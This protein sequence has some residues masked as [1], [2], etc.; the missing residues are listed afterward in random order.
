[1]LRTF[2]ALPRLAPLLTLTALAG[3]QLESGGA[4]PSTYLALSGSVPTVS[5]PAVD[6]AAMLAEDAGAEGQGPLRFGAEIAVDLGFEAGEWVT[7]DGGDR[8]W[9]MRVLSSGAYSLS[10]VFSAWDLPPGAE[11]YL[12]NDDRSWTFGQF[13]A[14]NDKPD[15]RMAIRPLAGEAVTLEYLE[16][17]WVE[18]PGVLRIGTVVHDYRDVNAILFGE[19]ADGDCEIDVQ[20]PQGVGWEDQVRAV[21]RLQVGG[22]LCSGSLVNNTS[23]DGKQ[24]YISAQHCGSMSTGIFSFKYQHSGCGTGIAPTGFSLQGAQ[25]LAES[26]TLDLQLGR[27]LT[28]IPSTYEPYL[29]GWDRTG[30]TPASTVTIHHPNG[31]PKKISFDDDPPQKSGTQ[32]RIV[33]WDLGVTEDG[34]SGAPLYSPQGRFVGQLCCGQATCDSPFNDYFGRLDAQWSQLAAHLDPLGTGQTTLDGHDPYAAPL[35]VIAVL[36]G[37]VDAL[38][39]GTAQTVSII[40]SGFTP[41]T[42]V[43]VDGVPVFGIPS[44]YTWVSSTLMTLDMPQVDHLGPTSVKVVAGTSSDTATVDVVAPAAPKIQAGT[45]DE[46]VTVFSFSG[47]DITL[48]SQPGDIVLLY[49]SPSGA[50]SSWPGVVELEI[51]NGFNSLYYTGAFTMPAK[52]WGAIHVNLG[53]VPPATTFFLEGVA[54]RAY[55][56]AFPLDSSNRQECKVLF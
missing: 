55:G 21:T 15:G 6:V 39:P 38:V 44:P 49:W 26:S 48:C 14:L 10:F 56:M 46:P 28:T 8:V 50:P 20:C 36:P 5:M 47:L 42:A 34:S 27:I 2:R 24:L 19:T 43:E 12:Y 13:N 40:G 32:W 41:A 1:M 25:V 30:S 22:L 33:E 31:G 35:D 23:K 17:A 3:A 53:A 52:A 37:T 7:L 18:H 54:I 45:G 4:P 11:L 9:R 51:G 29:A 16:P